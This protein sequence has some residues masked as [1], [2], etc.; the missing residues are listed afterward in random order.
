MT[1]FHVWYSVVDTLMV[2]FVYSK[3]S[4]EVADKQTRRQVNLSIMK[5]SW[6]IYSVEVWLIRLMMR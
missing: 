5:S 1:Q 3:P 2:N 4:D 6:R